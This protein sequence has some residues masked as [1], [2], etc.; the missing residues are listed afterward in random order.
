MTAAL[1]TELNSA[2]EEEA[3]AD[4][5]E[6]LEKLHNFDRSSSD[7]VAA[8][9][10]NLRSTIEK[11]NEMASFFGEDHANVSC[12]L[13]TLSEFIDHFSHAKQAHNRKAKKRPL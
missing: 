11:F 4:L 5:R 8:V 3:V 6:I 13:A 1:A 7:T 10:I 9:E 12:V 2:V